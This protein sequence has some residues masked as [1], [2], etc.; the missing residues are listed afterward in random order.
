MDS[1]IERTRAALQAIQ[2]AT[3]PSDYADLEA[4]ADEAADMRSATPAEALLQ[5][6]MLSGEVDRDGS[7]ER[8]AKLAESLVAY[9]ERSAGLDRRDYG[10]DFYAGPPQTV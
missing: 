7:H 9:I 5:A 4:I 6:A 1:L 10:F 8:M 3:K 2:T